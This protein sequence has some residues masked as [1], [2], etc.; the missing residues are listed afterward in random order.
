MEDPAG[1]LVPEVVPTA[2]LPVAQH[3]QGRGGQLGRERE[4][5][6][7]GEDAVAAEHR[8]EPRQ[9]CGRQALAAGDRW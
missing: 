1:V 9:T 2:A 4:R 5:L 7:A 6:E 8:H 3:A